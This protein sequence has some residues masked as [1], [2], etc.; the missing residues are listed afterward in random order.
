MQEL[1]PRSYSDFNLRFGAYRE[2]EG[3]HTF[4]VWVE[5]DTPGGTMRFDDAVEQ[6][7]NPKTFWEDP[8][9]G[10][11][12][13][14]GRLER[15]RATK[16]ELLQIGDLLAE[17]ALPLGPVRNLFERSLTTLGS[18]EGLRLRLHIDP[19]N[20]V[21]LPWE[22]IALRHASGQQNA[23]DFLSLRPEVSIVRTDTVESGKWKLPDRALAR[24]VAVLSS[25]DD[26]EELDIE[27]DKKSLENAVLKLNSNVPD[28]LVEIQWVERPATRVGLRNE[29]SNK[30]DILH[31]SGH[32]K[33]D[34]ITQRGEIILE[35]E[36]AGTGYESDY[37]TGE[38][39]AQLLPDAG[40]RLVVLGGCE[41][42]RRDGQNLWSG[43][44]AAITREKIPA[45][46]A[47]QFKIQDDNAIRIAETIYPLLLGGYTADEALFRARTAMYQEEGL[48]NRDWG[49]PVLYLHDKS[50][51]LFPTRVAKDEDVATASPFIKV[52]I[53]ARHVASNITGIV[54]DEATSADIEINIDELV[55]GE[56]V[57]AKF[58]TKPK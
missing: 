54:A 45:V 3:V 2:A 17:L 47:M 32:A 24:I 6:R 14:I 58:G 50:G 13:L 52:A 5:G 43:I 8:I 39:L 4:K 40:V 21:H 44:A 18:N 22:Y 38:Q 41:T 37:Y 33:F 48:E 11:G 29:L 9:R 28:G 53:R 25:P 26:Q 34:P 27:K 1:Q 30:A 12:G 46:V 56:V 51:V 49:A 42:A 16:E 15:R 57:G 36:R 55:N 7:F 20:L 19:V 35:K 10:M 23:T 31:Y